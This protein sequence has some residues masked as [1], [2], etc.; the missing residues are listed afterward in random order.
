MKTI[1]RDTPLI[2]IL[3]DYKYWTVCSIFDNDTLK[4]SEKYTAL[5]YQAKN[6]GYYL[7]KV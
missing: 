1:P 7:R 2:K 3:N 6:I 5:E 4:F